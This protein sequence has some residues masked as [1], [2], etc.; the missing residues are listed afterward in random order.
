MAFDSTKLNNIAGSVGTANLWIY[1]TTDAKAT[2][3][4]SG[5]FNDATD[6]GMRHEDMM[7]IIAGSPSNPDFVVV[8]IKVVSGGVSIH[9]I[10]TIA[11]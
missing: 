10:E 5:Y 9:D 3:A 1:H 11:A 2:V 8:G 4:G 7:M 6:F